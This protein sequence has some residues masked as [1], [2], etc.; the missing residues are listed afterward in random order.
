MI[1]GK[2]VRATLIAG[3]VLAALAGCQKQEGPAEKAGK[4]ID[5]TTEKVG[6]QIEKAGEK[7]Q[8]ATK[9]NGK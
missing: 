6:E 2:T 1:F 8:D 3:A 5:R 7:I 4:E 9:G